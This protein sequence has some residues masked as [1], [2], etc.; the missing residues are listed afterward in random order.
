MVN[1][2]II[3]ILRQAVRFRG[4]ET[5]FF[6]HVASKIMMK[7]PGILQTIDFLRRVFLKI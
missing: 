2:Y 1:Y 7:L 4:A 5:A 3:V 6:L